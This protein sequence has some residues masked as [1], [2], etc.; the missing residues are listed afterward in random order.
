MMIEKIHWLGHASF[1]IDGSQR[2]YI[3]PWKLANAPKADLILVT[4]DHFDHLS[5]PDIDR[6]RQQSTQIIT[7]ASCRQVLPDARIIRPGQRIELAGISIEAVYAYNVNKK[8]HPKSGD[9]AGYIFLLDGVKIYHA[10]DTDR[11][12]EMKEYR[13]DIALLP[14]SGTY[15]MTA[16]EAAES[17]A[18]VQ[19]QTAIPMHW[20]EI[21]G[22]RDDAERFK[23]LAPCNV[24]IKEIG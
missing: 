18:D 2:I 11:I 23:K 19:C 20:G 14:V 17:A 9:R 15:V 13:C 7:T 22:S 10:G 12:P 1:R 5:K 3:D 4:H 8:F 6:I 16:E 24:I 21:I